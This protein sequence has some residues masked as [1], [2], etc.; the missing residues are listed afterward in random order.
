MNV[1]M[2][3]R[4]PQLSYVEDKNFDYKDTPFENYI[5][6]KSKN[7]YNSTLPTTCELSMLAYELTGNS[8]KL[9]MYGAN[10]STFKNLITINNPNDLMKAI[11][12]NSPNGLLIFVHSSCIKEKEN[13]KDLNLNNDGHIITAIK[14]NN[15]HKTFNISNQWGVK[16]DRDYTLSELYNAIKG[17]K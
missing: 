6:G 3:N 8:T 17:V 13:D 15:D 10:N 14:L 9:L 7:Q 1:I 4:D 16:S 2:Q 12:A 5:Q 11:E